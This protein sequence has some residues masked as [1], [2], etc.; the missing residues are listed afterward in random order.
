MLSANPCFRYSLSTDNGRIIKVFNAHH[1]TLAPVVIE[2]IQAF[3]TH[4]AV[5]G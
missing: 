5:K 1:K 2:E 3:P 4:A